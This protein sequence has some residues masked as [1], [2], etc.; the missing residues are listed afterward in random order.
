MS[1]AINPIFIIGR[2]RSG[3]SHFWNIFNA[4]DNYCAW[5]EPLHPQLLS[6]IKYTDPKADHV[7]VEDYWANYRLLDDLTTFYQS[8]FGVN[9]LYLA[10]QDSWPELRHYIDFLISQSG[11]SHPVLQFNRMDLRW[12][13]LKGF[14]PQAKTLYLK[15]NPIQLWYSQRKHTP[16]SSHNDESYIDA[17]ELMQWSADLAADLPFLA[18]QKGRHGFFRFYVLYQLSIIMGTVKADVVIDLEEDVFNSDDY[19]V[20]LKTFG[21]NEEQL[22]EIQKYKSVPKKYEVTDTDLVVLS[23][24][25]TDVDLLLSESGLATGFGKISLSKI[26]QQNPDFWRRQQVDTQAV[27]GELLVAWHEAQTKQTEHLAKIKQLEA[28]L[29]NSL[30]TKDE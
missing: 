22:T 26:K 24:I 28:K 10:K 4:L 18:P 7:N 6:H 15:R 30:K 16:K 5:Y 21:L 12:S 8:N 17:Y 23:E 9:R 1:K 14:Y 20:K 13:W 2:F 11:N 27:A 25:M 29:I 19:L 3:T